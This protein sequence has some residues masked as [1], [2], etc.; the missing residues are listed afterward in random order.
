M[1]AY[2][3]GISGEMTRWMVSMIWVSLMKLAAFLPGTG[4]GLWV[5]WSGFVVLLSGFCESDM[6]S[7]E[8]IRSDAMKKANQALAMAR[9]M[10]VSKVSPFS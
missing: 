4:R 7:D 3:T 8:V 2:T 5:A 9:W 10:R 6:A 1:R